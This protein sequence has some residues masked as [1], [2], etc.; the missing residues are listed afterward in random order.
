LFKNPFL[1]QIS[2]CL[3]L[4]LEKEEPTGILVTPAPFSE[5]ISKPLEAIVATLL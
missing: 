4:Q 3:I 1:I 2:N 5:F